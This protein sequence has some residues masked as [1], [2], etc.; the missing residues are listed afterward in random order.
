MYGDRGLP[1]PRLIQNPHP[2]KG[3]AIPQYAEACHKLMLALGYTE[4][5]TQ[6]G[7]WGSY[8]TRA[9]GRAYPKHCR[10]THIN[11]ASASFPKP[12]Q[13]LLF[14]QFLFTPFTPAERVR[15]RRMKN[16]LEDGWGYFK[17]QS[18]KPQTI[19]YSQADSPAGLLAWIYEKLHAWT[20]R[21]P[22][23]DDEIL[24]W[25]SIFSFSRAGPAAPSRIYYEAMHDMQRS[26]V[27]THT[28][29]PEVKLGISYFPGEILNTPK[30]WANTMGPVVF[31]KE[32]EKGGHFAAWERPEA[33]VSDLR[34]MFGK[35]GGA[36]GVVKGRSGYSE[37]RESRL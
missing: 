32:H 34:A 14:L 27:D 5:V 30:L 24:T 10:A 31:Q 9:I 25:V 8:I 13:P 16:V 33:M 7:D 37:N 36:Y 21:Y 20:D 35:T 4:Y 19:G 1:A 26:L 22:W 18:T 15:L 6:G 23:T 29:L 17:I 12:N 3:F 11:M 28:W 2:Q